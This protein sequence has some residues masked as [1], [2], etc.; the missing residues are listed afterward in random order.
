M[1]LVE[2]QP[3][4]A[5]SALV[6]EARDEGAWRVLPLEGIFEFSYLDAN[7]RPS[8]RRVSALE[9]KVGPGKLLLGGIDRD[10]GV[11]RGFRVDRIHTLKSVESGEV[12]SR[13]ILDWLL[14]RATALGR[15]RSRAAAA[16]SKTAGRSV[17]GKTG[18]RAEVRFG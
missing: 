3:L 1:T 2:N 6:A 8:L 13:N 4:D 18:R 9:L 14:G 11:Y 10:L 17:G 15:A 16:S 7:G 12:V 5:G